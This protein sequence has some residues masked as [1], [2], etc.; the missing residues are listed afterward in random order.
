MVG[1]T[2]KESEEPRQP[3]PPTGQTSDGNSGSSTQ[4]SAIALAGGRGRWE[5]IQA[6]LTTI[7]AILALI[8][9]SFNA[10]Q[11]NKHPGVSLVL[12]NEIRI[13]PVPASP[14][15][16]VFMHPTLAVDRKSDLTTVVKNFTLRLHRTDGGSESDADLLWDQVG[17]YTWDNS[18]SDYSYQFVSEATPIVVTSDQAQTPVLRFM[19]TWYFFSVGHWEGELTAYMSDD[20][21]VTSRFCIDIMDTEMRGNSDS[22]TFDLHPGLFGAPADC[23]R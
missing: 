11:M 18:S 12:A 10:I 9:S 8:L 3:N 14:V 4:N 2:A 13:R 1:G 20:S 5:S 22:R 15:V 6:W 21:T 7:I 19:S 23:Y 17:Q 16:L